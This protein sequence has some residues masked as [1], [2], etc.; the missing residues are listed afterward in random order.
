MSNYRQRASGLW[1]PTVPRVCSFFDMLPAA[2]QAAKKAAAGGGGSGPVTFV[3]DALTTDA[4]VT[5]REPNTAW[6]YAAGGATQPDTGGVNNA[7]LGYGVK[8]TGQL[9]PD[10]TAIADSKTTDLSVEVGAKT[11]TVWTTLHVYADNASVNNIQDSFNLYCDGTNFTI[12]A[13]V[14]TFDSTLATAAQTYTAGD[15]IKLSITKSGSNWNG[16]AYKNGIEV[17]SFTNQAHAGTLGQ[18]SV[19]E[20]LGFSGA[21]ATYKDALAT[22]NG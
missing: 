19:I 12:R 2:Q 6:T 9:S 11:G 14:G 15:I 8:N 4:S 21:T 16:V 5:E 13:R 17:C 10:P 20:Y 3:N 18:N 22:S 7:S 1:V